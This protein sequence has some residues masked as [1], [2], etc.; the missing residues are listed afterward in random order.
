ML[1]GTVATPCP[2]KAP[3]QGP[4]VG[5][6]GR[7]LPVLKHPNFQHVNDWPRVTHIQGLLHRPLRVLAN[8]DQVHP[9]VDGL[10][11]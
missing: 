4:F 9:P 1:D 6:Y 7:W 5:T 11:N 8:Q 10:P 3:K 2:K